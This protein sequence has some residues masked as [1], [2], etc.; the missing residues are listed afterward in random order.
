MKNLLR[1]TLLYK[2]IK[3]SSR[4]DYYRH[5]ILLFMRTI[6]KSDVNYLKWRY[7]FKLK[8]ELSLENPKTFN[9]KIQ[10]MKLYWKK[11]SLSKLVDKYEARSY[12]KEFF[13]D[14]LLND[15]YDVFDDVSKIDLSKLPQSFVLKA[16]HASGLNFICR[17]KDDICWSKELKRMKTW[18]KIDYYKNELEWVY[19][20]IKPRIICE[21]Y[22]CD[23]KG[24]PPMDYKFFCFDGEPLFIQVDIDKYG[25]PRRNIYNCNWQ[26][27][28]F[29]IRHRNTDEK[30]KKPIALEKMVEVARKLSEGFR[31]LRID[32]Y[33]LE[34]RIFFG[35][36]TFFPAAGMLPFIPEEYDRIIG[37]YLILPESK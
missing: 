24:Q 27:Q 25:E 34:G 11:E 37:E 13:G 6:L 29:R 19:K 7:K 20:E 8:K 4:F 32:L 18:L 2:K 21:K 33:N 3:N 12:V 10:W 5:H 31:F 22:L 17:N 36:V 1:K 26:L 14:D 28:E 15:V 9:E 23:S 30:L 16:T 35:E